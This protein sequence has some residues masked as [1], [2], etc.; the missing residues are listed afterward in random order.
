LGFKDKEV[1][2]YIY[3]ENMI[4]MAFGI[5]L[6]FVLGKLLHV[7]VMTTVESR[8][9]MFGRDIHTISYLY[10]AVLTMVFSFGVNIITSRSLRKINMVEALKSIE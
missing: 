9:I 6:G 5:L 2:S 3:R 7:Y 4:L 10:A 1:D 8:L